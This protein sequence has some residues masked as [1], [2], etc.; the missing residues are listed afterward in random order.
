MLLQYSKDKGMEYQEEILNSP[1]FNE[2][3]W[4]KLLFLLNDTQNWL[5]EL[6]NGIIM[7]VPMKDRKKLFRRTYYI[8]VT[9]LTHIMERHY[10]KV[11]RHPE[12]SKFTI[13]VA[14][15]LSYLRDASFEQAI[16]IAGSL[17]FQRIINTGTVIGFDR[18][19]LP[20]SY[21]MVVTDSGGRIITAYPGNNK[22]S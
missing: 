20:T 9:S 13:P 3:E 19:R 10:Y 1:P 14:K 5:N 15:I 22:N 18:D 12:T 21:I 6:V 8:S 11:L 4:L 17:N 2:D 7:Q 16:P